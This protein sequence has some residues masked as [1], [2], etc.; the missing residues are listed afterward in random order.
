MVKLILG[1][2]DQ[3]TLEF[4]PTMRTTNPTPQIHKV[5]LDTTLL[6]RTHGSSRRSFSSVNNH[7]NGEM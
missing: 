7:M 6:D 4:F 1:D 5:L 3:G 2:V